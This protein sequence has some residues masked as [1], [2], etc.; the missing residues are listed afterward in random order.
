MCTNVCCKH[1]LKYLPLIESS[2]L[3]TL[4]NTSPA[5]TIKLS[6]AISRRAQYKHNIVSLVDHLLSGMAAA[7][8]ATDCQLLSKE[9]CCQLYSADSRT[10]VVRQTYSN[11]VDWCFTAAGPKLWKSLPA[12]L[13]QTDIG[14]E[15]FKW[16]R[17][18]SF[19]LVLRLRCIDPKATV[20][21]RRKPP[22]NVLSHKPPQNF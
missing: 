9:G 6:S 22:W 18:T 7:Y 8:P 4:W 12:D 14:C 10:C 13:R 2:L 19:V 5:H 20:L 16:L 3:R 17:K 1:W 21:S 11:F 15:Q